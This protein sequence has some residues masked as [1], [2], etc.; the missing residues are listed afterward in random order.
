MPALK[1]LSLALVPAPPHAGAA[2]EGPAAVGTL[3][4]L[5]ARVQPHVGLQVALLPQHLEGT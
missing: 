4:G 1:V 3:E 2:A 5:L